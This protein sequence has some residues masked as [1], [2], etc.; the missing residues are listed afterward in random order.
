[1]QEA[2]NAASQQQQSLQTMAEA[3]RSLAIDAQELQE[4]L[5]KFSV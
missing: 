1:M 2:A 5:A 4:Q 3:S